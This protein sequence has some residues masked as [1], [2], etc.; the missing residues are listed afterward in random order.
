MPSYGADPFAWLE[1]ALAVYTR[2]RFDVLLPTQEQVA[3]LSAVPDRLREAGI[4]TAVP[5]FDGLARLQDKLSAFATLRELGL[6]QPVASVITSP[7]ELAAWPDFPL[8]LKMPIGTATAGVRR[9][10]SAADLDGLPPSW[11]AAAQAGGLLAQASVSGRLAMVQSVFDHGRMVAFHANA[12]LREGARGGASHKRSL[13]LPTVH[14]QMALLGKRL[15]WHGALSADAILGP[16]G[17]VFIDINPRLVEPVN[18]LRSGVDLVGAMLDLASRR[19]AA[20]Q[21]LGRTGV[22]TH[23]LL[24]AILGAADR[25]GKRRDVAA[26]LG[27]ALSRRGSYRNSAEELTPT[28]RDPRAVSLIALAAAV[29]LTRPAAWRWFASDSV[30]AYALTPEG[31]SR[32]LNQRPGRL[33]P[34]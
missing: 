15:S 26:E 29:N 34:S 6:P 22:D 7:Q 8:Y 9:I 24:L 33:H 30:T 10:E 25:R 3:V 1:A 23:Q 20:P 31:W 11:V 4:A 18:A 5:P 17:P 21:P 16:D 27:A 13:D 12:R 28:R 14:G 2:G 32:I 19:P